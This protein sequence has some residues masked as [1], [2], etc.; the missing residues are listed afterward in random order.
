MLPARSST[1]CLLNQIANR[2]QSLECIEGADNSL[3]INC[4]TVID[5]VLT[6]QPETAPTGCTGGTRINETSIHSS[7]GHFNELYVCQT[8]YFKYVAAENLPT[9][10]TGTTGPTGLIGPTGMALTGPTGMALTGPTG[11]E[12]PTGGNILTSYSISPVIIT[13]QTLYSSIPEYDIYQLNSVGG[14]FQIT[15]PLAASLRMHYFVDVGGAL[16]SNPVI[17][18]C[19]GADQIAGDTSVLMNVDYSSVAVASS[20]PSRWMII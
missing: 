12:G 7:Y 5:G 15:L 19:Q 14:S 10:P 2:I 20:P 16:S 1:N 6:F 3:T 9:G 8:G 4:D 17:I 11:I 18:Q 13:S